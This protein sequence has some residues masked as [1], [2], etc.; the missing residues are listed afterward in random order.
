MPKAEAQIDRRYIA[1]LCIASLL[2]LVAGVWFR[3]SRTPPPVPS[4]LETLNMQM[5]RQRLEFERRSM[6][7]SRKAADLL[8]LAADVRV[9]P[10]SVP[11]HLTSP[12]ET[13]VLLASDSEGQPLWAAT[14]TVGSTT[15][16]CDDVPV[17]EIAT[18]ITIP[19]TLANAVAFDLDNNLAGLVIPCGTGSLLTTPASFKAW[20][21]ERAVEQSLRECCGLQVTAALGVFAVDSE[22]ELAKRGLRVGDVL[23]S[24]A[25][26]PVSSRAEL[27]SAL[28]ASP[29]PTELSYQR[30]ERIRK[31]LL[32]RTEAPQ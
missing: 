30:G 5:A 7:Y 6:F 11:F 26:Q 32:P 13:V 10:E 16:P 23:V 4:E 18:T 22:S 21:A 25:G 14:Q 27:H 19:A 9:H 12:G 8:T 20:N 31:L 17:Q 3:P 28:T 1:A 29:P 24:V 15:T 2:I